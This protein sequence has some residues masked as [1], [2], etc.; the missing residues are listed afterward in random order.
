MEKKIIALTLCVLMAW[1]DVSG[2]FA[3]TPV[4]ATLADLIKR[5]YLELLEAK[6]LPAAVPSSEFEALKEQLKQDM[7]AEEKKLKSEE[8]QLKGQIESA[9]K[10]LERLNRLTSRDTKEMGSQRSDLHCQILG[11]EKQLAEKQM[12]RKQ[13]LPAALDNK[14][15]KL[16][17]IQQWPAKKREIDQIIASERA[18]DRRFGNVED[19]GI[20]KISEDQEKDLKVGEE[21]VR[22]MKAYGLMPPELEDKDVTAYIQKLAE[23]IAA[24]SDLKVPVKVTVLDSDEINAFAL[25]GGY[26]FVNTGILAKAETESELVGVIAHE[27]AHASARHGARL[28]KRATIANYIFQGA[29]LAA[30]LFTGGIASLGAYYAMQYGFMG[31]GMVMNLALLGV[32][33]DYEEEADQ[34][35]AQYTWKAGWAP[36]GFV[37]FFDKMAS[38]KGHVKS[39]SFFR[40]HPPFFERIVSTF[41]EITYLP[42][43]KDMQVDSTEFHEI[44]DRFQKLDQEIRT[45]K[46]NR[47]TLRRGGECSE[48]IEDRRLS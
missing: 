40:T 35:G 24:N 5:S 22:E 12:S 9:Q 32:S 18:R 33:R 2:A 7:K 37:T 16:D 39:A 15:A 11:M 30:A 25:P 8:E 46:K 23:K 20:R 41:S 34:L 6:D 28:M 21:A 1:M 4:P 19:I 36:M 10:E 43:K 45:E 48:P 44:K 27:I 14:L 26:L 29:Q 42:P 38:E 17:L 47:P 3:Q 31:L 13:G